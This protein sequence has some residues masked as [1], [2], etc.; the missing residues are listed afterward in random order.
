MEIVDN[1]IAKINKKYEKIT[2][3]VIPKSIFRIFMLEYEEKILLLL[4]KSVRNKFPKQIN[5]E[6]IS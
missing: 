3:V 5:S 4:Q 1:N 2:Y 6:I